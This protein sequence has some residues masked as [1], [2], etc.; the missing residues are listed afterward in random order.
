MYSNTAGNTKPG[1]LLLSSSR[2]YSIPALAAIPLRVERPSL[3]GRPSR[4]AAA[5]ADAEDG[6]GV[7]F[8]TV[9]PDLSLRSH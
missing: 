1:L 3:R 7:D 5:R 8:S 6:I 4:T 2:V 9:A